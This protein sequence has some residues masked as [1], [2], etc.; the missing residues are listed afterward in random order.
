MKIVFVTYGRF[1]SNSG[2]HVAGFANRLA[3]RGHR[4]AVFSEGD[5]AGAADFGPVRFHAAPRSALTQTQ[6]RPW[7]ST[8]SPATPSTP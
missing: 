1:D 3:Q 2:A 4:V 6:R 7:P 8:A 5:P